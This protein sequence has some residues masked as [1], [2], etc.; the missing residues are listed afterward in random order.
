[1]KRKEN[2]WNV[3]STGDPRTTHLIRALLPGIKRDKVLFPDDSGN[4]LDY[5]N[6]FKNCLSKYRK[7][8]L[9]NVI[10]IM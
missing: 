8:E 3:F 9:K 6:N 2:P 5:E 10:Y 7:I 1:M 4:F